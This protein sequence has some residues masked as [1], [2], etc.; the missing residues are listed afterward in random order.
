MT[1]GNCTQDDTHF[2]IALAAVNHGLHVLVTKP[3]VKTL[4]HHQEL[5]AAARRNNVLVRVSGGTLLRCLPTGTNNITTGGCWV[6]GCRSWSKC[7]SGLTRSMLMLEIESRCVNSVVLCCSMFLSDC[8]RAI[9]GDRLHLRCLCLFSGGL[10]R[11]GD[12]GYVNAYM[13]QPKMQLETFKA[14]AGKASDISYYLNSHHIDF[15]EVRCV[16]FAWTH[17][18]QRSW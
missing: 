12:F 4:A 16:C 7:T 6:G 10:Q 5:A 11:M 2:K 13:S 3:A 14:W 9:Y 1:C 15:H 18:G 8:T 17:R